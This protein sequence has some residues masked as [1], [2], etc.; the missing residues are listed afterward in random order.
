MNSSNLTVAPKN[1]I[2]EPVGRIMNNISRMYLAELHKKLNHLEIQR[3]YYPLM[4]IEAGN[5][6]LTQQELAT[7]LACD[8]VQVVRIIDYLSKQGYVNRSQDSNDR[9]KY[10]LKITEKAKKA[11]PDIKR[12]IDETN[13][14][15]LD[16]LS[17]HDIAQLYSLLRKLETNLSANKKIIL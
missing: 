13:S 3:S 9:R 10:N 4:L 11:I 12:T 5:G 7:K 16:N 6:K 14:L 15:A 17:E 8:K 1:S 2:R